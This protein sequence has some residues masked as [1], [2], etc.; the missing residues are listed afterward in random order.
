M[1]SNRNRRYTSYPSNNL[2]KCSIVN[3]SASS[4]LS[5]NGRT[6]AK[7]WFIADDC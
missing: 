3:I 5:K 2:I 1:G 6:S 4:F 7:T